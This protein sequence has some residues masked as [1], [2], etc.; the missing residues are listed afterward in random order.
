[1]ANKDVVICS[2]VLTAIGTYGGT[3]KEMPATWRWNGLPSGNGGT[4]PRL[5]QIDSCRV[6]HDRRR[7]Y[8]CGYAHKRLTY[9]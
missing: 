9:R 6:L 7:C 2:P 3:Y 4:L 5:V 8:I 1:M